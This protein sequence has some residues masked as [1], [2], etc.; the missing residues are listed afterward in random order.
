MR[1]YSNVFQIIGLTI[2]C[3]FV[4]LVVVIKEVH[5]ITKWAKRANMICTEIYYADLTNTH[6][7]QGMAS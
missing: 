3:L 1:R 2:L 6:H 7:Y 4:V 5:S